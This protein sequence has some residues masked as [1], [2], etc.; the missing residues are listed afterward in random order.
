M[1][2]KIIYIFKYNINHKMYNKYLKL[3]KNV[4]RGYIPENIQR[5]VVVKTFI[6]PQCDPTQTCLE[7]V[8][9]EILVNQ[10]K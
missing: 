2:L 5:Q 6:G 4:G 9:L 10:W 3:Y 7:F 8:P 1:K